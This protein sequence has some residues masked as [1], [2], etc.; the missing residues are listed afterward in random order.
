MSTV[1][2]RVL[3]TNAEMQAVQQLE[4]RV[5]NMSPLPVHQT[6]TACQNGGLMLGAFI[7]DK[8]VGFSYS[9]AGFNQGKSYLCSH[10]LGIDPD[11]QERGIGA[12]LKQAQK[13]YASKL[14]YD[15]MVWTFDPL[16][17]RNGYLNLSKLR[18]VCSTYVENCY[19]EMEDDLNQGLPTDRFKVEWWLNS[20]H[21]NDGEPLSTEGAQQPFEW[22]IEEGLPHLVNV[23]QSMEALVE[24]QPV[25]VPAPASFQQI[26]Q[27]DH[28]LAVDWRLKVRMIFQ[29]LFAKGYV[30]VSLLKRDQQPVHHYY[31][32]QRK[33]LD[34]S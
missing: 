19:G 21:V 23:E 12:K 6:I 32:V 26:K 7:A 2:M 33:S 27:T 10:M 4:E 17:T 1:K 8:L 28:S 5:W 15:L 16:E 3:K 24:G 22:K 18:A 31:L 14:G 29:A 25:L 34:I 20:P 11:Y 13:E 30:A 9:F